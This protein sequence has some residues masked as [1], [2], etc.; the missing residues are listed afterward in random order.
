MFGIFLIVGMALSLGFLLIFVAGFSGRKRNKAT[1]SEVEL[2][3]F[4]RF[5]RAISDLTEAMKLE[6]LEANQSDDEQSLDIYAENRTPIT[7]GRYLIHAELC[8][9]E[10]I[11][12]AAEIVEFSNVIV[13]DRLSKG[14]FITTGRFTPD[15]PAISELAPIEFI[16]GERLGELTDKYRIALKDI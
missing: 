11:T 5:V 4:T 8:P 1:A 10:A 9:R 13:Q 14:L 15:L 7:G 2:P 6:I 16:D 3:S 12:S